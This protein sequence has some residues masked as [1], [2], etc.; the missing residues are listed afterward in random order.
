MKL[1]RPT[2]AR[3]LLL[4]AATALSNL[5][6]APSAHAVLANSVNVT[7]NAPG[8]VIG[9]VSP[10]TLTQVATL[11]AGIVAADG[12]AIGNYMLDGE[13]I[14]FAGDSVRVQIAAGAQLG[15]GSY[16]TG[17]LGSG[18]VRATYLLDNLNISGRQIT[19]YTVTAF[20]GYANSGFIG[21]SSAA[22]AAAAVQLL[23]PNSL[24]INLDNF[25]FVDRGL[26]GARNYANLR[27]DL[28]S[29]VPEPGTA[30]LLLA[31]GGLLLWL[32]MW[33]QRSAAGV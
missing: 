9:N 4:A 24:R 13:A 11:A 19:G 23:T 10:L 7:L 3:R 30:L 16:V 33:R 6:L 22:S 27:I 26:G 28:V 5:L 25:I 20:D 29:V 8:G 31:G 1:T 2:P 21:L 12:G 14:T 17:Y 32:P 18:A 15:N